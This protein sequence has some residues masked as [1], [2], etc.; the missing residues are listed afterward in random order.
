MATNDSIR[1]ILRTVT[2]AVLAALASA[3][4]EAHEAYV[5]FAYTPKTVY[6]A[7]F[8]DHAFRA[9]T[10]GMTRDDVLQRLGAPIR[11]FSEEN[12]TF[13]VYSDIGHYTSSSEKAY[14]Q[15]WLAVNE[16]GRVVYVFRRTITADE[17]PAY[18]VMEWVLGDNGVFRPAIGAPYATAGVAVR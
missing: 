2:I 15:R 16:S 5:E 3:C 10:V 9:L 11:E 14:R 6:A 1:T 17:N 4:S 7:A 8:D 18:P 12:I 13:L